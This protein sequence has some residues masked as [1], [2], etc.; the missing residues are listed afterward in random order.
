MTNL[1]Q[2]A[3]AQLRIHGKIPIVR[4]IQRSIAFQVRDNALA[5]LQLQPFF[6]TFTF[7]RSHALKVMPNMMPYCSVYFLSEQLLPDGDYNAGEVRFDTTVRLGF[8]VMLINNDPDQM[9]DRLDDCYQYIMNGLLR[10]PTFIRTKPFLPYGGPGDQTG[11][12]IEGFLRGQRQHFYGI[13]GLQNNETPYAEL[14]L[15]LHCNLGA[16]EYEPYVEN[17]L[18][19]VH[20]ETV[21]PPGDTNNQHIFSIYDVDMIGDDDNG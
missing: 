15:E 20:V 14:R 11:Y 10:D 16:I 21:H 13:A 3:A 2:N 6:Q 7:K 19:T 18:E 9:E 1:S 17:M 4:N 12:V 8:S 5:K